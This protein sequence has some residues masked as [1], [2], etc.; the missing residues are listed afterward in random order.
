M[1]F[2][3]KNLF[4]RNLENPAT[5][6]ANPAMWLVN[7]FGGITS[8]GVTITQDNSLGITAVWS[9]VNRIADNIATMKVDVVEELPSGEKLIR[10][11]DRAV[12]AD[13]S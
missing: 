8:S 4:R 7:M 2:S 5:S 9:A 11:V 12:A 6:L 1:A 13:R 3:F 10:N